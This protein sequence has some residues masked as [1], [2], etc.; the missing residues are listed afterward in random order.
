[1]A[2]VK[3]ILKSKR[4]P[5]SLYI[6]FKAGREIDLT[7]STGF[8]IDPKHWSSAKQSMKNIVEEN[9]V[10]QS[11]NIDSKYRYDK[12]NKSLNNL[13]EFIL[14]SF[15]EAQCNGDLID[16][17]WLSDLIIKCFNR[18][19][20]LEKDD[21]VFFVPYVEKYIEQA[22]TK[23]RKKTNKPVSAD[24]IKAYKA[25]LTKLLEFE[26]YS[27]KKIKYRDLNLNFH[28]E[29]LHFLHKVQNVLLFLVS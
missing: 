18:P 12:L 26:K 8:S 24:T 29:F 1:M 5:A 25:T 28:K 4:N 7:V 10:L 23:I 22:P 2:T 6:R 27:G 20:N 19:I 17:D 13:K 21:R 15:N 11:H 9:P 16:K 3:F 14:Y